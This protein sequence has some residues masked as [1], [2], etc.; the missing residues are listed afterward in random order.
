L[1]NYLLNILVDVLSFVNC[2]KHLFLIIFTFLF[3]VLILV[4][5]QV[6]LTKFVAKAQIA[7]KLCFH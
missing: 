5:E 2:A 6:I 3:N 4:G 7:H 1:V